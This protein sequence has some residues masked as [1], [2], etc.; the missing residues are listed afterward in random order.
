MTQ[1]KF[2]NNKVKKVDATP[3]MKEQALGFAKSIIL[4]GNQYSRLLPSEI[5]ASG[6]VTEQQKIEIQRTYVGKLGEL[7]FLK[8]LRMNGKEVDTYGMLDIYEGE[9]N[10]DSYDFKTADGKTV[11]VKTGF[12]KIHSRLLINIEQFDNK[13]KDYYVA[14]KLNA[15]DTDS[16]KKLVDWDSIT[17]GSVMGY[18]EY[19]YLAKNAK[20][21]DWGEGPARY[22]EYYRLMGVDRLLSKF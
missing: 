8:Y 2:F 10:V 11:D 21:K 9:A 3:E 13:K 19:S 6:D 22:I 4:S 12:R 7:V 14:V 20:V 16:R 15:E 18:A 17:E 5:R 1:M